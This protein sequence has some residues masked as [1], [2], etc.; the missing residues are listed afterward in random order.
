MIDEADLGRY[1]K[2]YSPGRPLSRR[3]A[4]QL[5]QGAGSGATRDGGASLVP[6]ERYR[7]KERLRRLQESSE[8]LDLLTSFL[9]GRADKFELSCAPGDLAEFRKDPRIRLSGVSHPAAGLLSNAEVEAY[10]DLKDYEALS[11]DWFLVKVEAGRRPNVLLHVVDDLPAELPLLLI[12][13]DLADRMGVRERRAALE[14]LGGLNRS[15]C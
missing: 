9:A 12:A 6:I 2:P 3:S 4:W 1:P 10:V 8:P 13:A 7:R 11:G 15:L 5:I 14:I